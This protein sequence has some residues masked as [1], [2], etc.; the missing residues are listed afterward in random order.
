MDI[1]KIETLEEAI[2]LRDSNKLVG[3]FDMDDDIYHSHKLRAMN[4]SGLVKLVQSPAHYRAWTREPQKD[5]KALTF[6]RMFH[7]A[8]LEPDKF[9]KE[10]ISASGLGK[11]DL[12]KAVDKARLQ[13]FKDQNP[14]KTI[15]TKEDYDTLLGMQEA[16]YSHPY[17]D[18]LLSDGQAE[19]SYFWKE[20]ETGVLCKARFDYLNPRL[21]L[22]LDPKTTEDASDFAKSAA[23]WNYHIQNAFYIDAVRNFADIRTVM[24]FIVVEKPIPHGVRLIK[25]SPDD[26]ETGREV[27]KRCLRRFAECLSTNSWPNYKYDITEV[28]LPRWKLT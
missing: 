22:L 13:E 11:L 19:I 10:Y 17:I 7:K 2:E 26:I 1:I 9:K 3:L 8:I 12:R 24:I 27:Y 18:N 16:V 4:Q 28:E 21:D 20:R 6:G 23:Q 15:I 5:T 25:L 14:D